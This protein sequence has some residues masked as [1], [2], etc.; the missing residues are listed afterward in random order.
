[1]CL[2]ARRDKQ[3]AF[4]AFRILRVGTL[5]EIM[6]YYVILVASNS[7]VIEKN[8][9]FSISFIN[10]YFTKCSMINI[11]QISDQININ[12]GTGLGR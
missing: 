5:L 2:L 6:K 10:S 9:I 3:P 7:A 1:M 11:V 4:W 8:A 12:M